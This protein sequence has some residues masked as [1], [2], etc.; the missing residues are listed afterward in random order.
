MCRVISIAGSLADEHRKDEGNWRLSLLGR[1]D[2]Q[3]IQR[4]GW[5]KESQSKPI[6][7]SE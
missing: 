3:D 2:I 6:V 4:F 7:L 5:L 1:R